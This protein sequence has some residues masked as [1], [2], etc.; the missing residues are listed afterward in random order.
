MGQKK[1]MGNHIRNITSDRNCMM[2][3]KD[4]INEQIH[5]RLEGIIQFA[6]HHKKRLE[7][8][9]LEGT[10]D[11]QNNLNEQAQDEI[12]FLVLYLLRLFP[13]G[14]NHYLWTIPKLLPFINAYEAE[15]LLTEEEEWNIYGP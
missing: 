4:N 10:I 7:A 8:I 14:E 13:L 2:M 5:H 9:E 3:H 11:L 12:L 1:Y 6:T 15:P